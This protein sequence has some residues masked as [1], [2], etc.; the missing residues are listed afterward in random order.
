MLALTS[1]HSSFDKLFCSELSFKPMHNHDAA[2]VFKEE[3]LNHH[4][5]GSPMSQVYK[6]C[7]TVGSPLVIFRGTVYPAGYVFTTRLSAKKMLRFLVS[8][9]IPLFPVQ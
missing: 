7:K 4:P 1:V 8:P 2:T 3:K 9:V 6:R 5:P